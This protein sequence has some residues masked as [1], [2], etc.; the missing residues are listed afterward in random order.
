MTVCPRCSSR[1]RD[2]PEYPGTGGR[3][4]LGMWSPKWRMPTA[5]MLWPI[6][7]RVSAASAKA[8]AELSRD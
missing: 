1:A 8:V 6:F 2:I 4:P 3:S 7:A 5:S